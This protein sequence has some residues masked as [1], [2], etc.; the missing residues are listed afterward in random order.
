M[1]DPNESNSS[2]ASFLQGV[3]A[4]EDKEFRLFTSAINR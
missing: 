4:F 2:L 3:L 1:S